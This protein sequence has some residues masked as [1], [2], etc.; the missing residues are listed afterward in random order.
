ML[1]GLS[2]PHIKSLCQSQ[3]FL[4]PTPRLSIMLQFKLTFYG[5]SFVTVGFVVNKFP[6]DTS[7][8][9]QALFMVVLV[10]SFFRSEVEPK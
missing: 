7:F 2:S 4:E 6:R 10:K 3:P 1:P 9:G 5:N 8:S